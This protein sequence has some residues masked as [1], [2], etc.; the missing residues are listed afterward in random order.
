MDYVHQAVTLITAAKCQRDWSDICWFHDVVEC[1]SYAMRL[2][3]SFISKPTFINIKFILRLQLRLLQDPNPMPL[4]MIWSNQLF[5]VFNVGSP[6]SVVQSLA[7]IELTLVVEDCT[8][9]SSCCHAECNGNSAY[10]VYM[11]KGVFPMIIHYNDVIWASWY[12]KFHKVPVM[13]KSDSIE[14]RHHTDIYIDIWMFTF[15]CLYLC[16]LSFALLLHGR[17]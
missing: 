13:G 7:S 10:I 9:P 1:Y 8:S 14:W 15:Y 11:I 2:R 3:Q 6:L 5:Q 12:T 16:F 4:L 17:M